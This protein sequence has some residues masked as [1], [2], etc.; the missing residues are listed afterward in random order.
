MQKQSRT[1]LRVWTSETGVVF[2]LSLPQLVLWPLGISK[3][4]WRTL[5]LEL[6]TFRWYTSRVWFLKS[7]FERLGEN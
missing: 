4:L 5:T 7:K 1:L 6:S 3:V 2:Q